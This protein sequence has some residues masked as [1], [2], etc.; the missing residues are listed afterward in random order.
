MN[1]DDVKKMLGYP[2][3]TFM[4]GSH[5][6][7]KATQSTKLVE[8]FGY[9]HVCVRDV[10]EAEAK[11]GSTE[12]A[13]IKRIMAKGGLIDPDTSVKLLVDHLIANPARNY[14]IDGFPRSVEQAVYFEQNVSEC[15]TLLYYDV[16]EDVM[17]DRLVSRARSNKREIDLEVERKKYHHYKEESS[18][19][20]DLYERFGKVRRIDANGSVDDVYSQTKAA[21]LPEIYFMIGPKA[22]GKSA[23]SHLLGE[24]TN[25]HVLK[26]GQFFKNEGVDNKDD[27]TKVFKLISWL[28]ETVHPRTLL[29][30]FPQN[31][32][33][34]RCFSQNCTAPSRIFWLNCSRDVSQERMITLGKHHPEY[35]PSAILSKKIREFHSQ[36]PT[37][38]PFLK[39]TF[40]DIFH[41][42]DS[43]QELGF[44]FKTIN[45]IVQ[46][47]I[48]HI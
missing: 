38:Q 29:E 39:D 20:V 35:V 4:I 3:I 5:G 31:R 34:A 18:A 13:K 43:E 8:E 11:K 36:L 47:T 17:I 44:V 30:G 9:T 21:M 23:V 48:I 27:E 2:K 37:L 7:G 1:T 46:P 32:I 6:S 33:Q 28:I 42:I 41:E 19:V 26:V 12:G 14:L 15:Q 25:T 16:S 45:E 40:P 10:M 24:K 22:S